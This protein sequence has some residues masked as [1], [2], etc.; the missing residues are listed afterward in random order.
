MRTTVVL[1]DELVAK[2]RELSKAKT[3]SGLLNTC[4]ADWISRHGRQEIEA[5]LAVEYRSGRA[6]SRRVIRDF[7]AVD[8][9]GWPSW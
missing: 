2:A 7:V 1:R 5:R 6:E 3:L 4:L 8:K 9:E